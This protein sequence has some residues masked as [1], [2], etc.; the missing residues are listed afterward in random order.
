MRIA[1][2]LAA[3]MALAACQG[4]DAPIPPAYEAKVEEART[5]LEEN[6][7]GLPRPNFAFVRIR[8]RMDGG[9]LVTFVERGGRH[10]GMFSVAMQGPEAIDGWGGWAGGFGIPDVDA[11]GEIR[12]FFSESP[13]AACPPVPA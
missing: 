9:L 11:D 10:D 5:S 7:E 8:C 6:W 1:V 3:G 4:G 12:H 2:F 13:E